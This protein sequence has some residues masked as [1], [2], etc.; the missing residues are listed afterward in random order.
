M[1]ALVVG[2]RES[3]SG[4]VGM[5]P[6]IG[7]NSG[8]E[9]GGAGNRGGETADAD[10]GTVDEKLEFVGGFA[11]KVA[12]VEVDGEDTIL[13][14]GIGN[15][16]HRYGSFAD[17][18]AG[19]VDAAIGGEAIL[20]KLTEEGISAVVFADRQPV[21]AYKVGILHVRRKFGNQGK[22][23]AVRLL[24]LSLRIGHMGRH[25]PFTLAPMPGVVYLIA[26]FATLGGAILSCHNDSLCYTE[27]TEK[28]GYYCVERVSM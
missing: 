2:M 26:E 5:E 25:S 27:L 3:G 21:E 24:C 28:A 9:A 15:R 16:N 18:D 20:V 10:G 7:K 11:A 1:E 8:D 12:A 14:H 6:F 23:A 4:G 22:V 19:K 13:D 17:D